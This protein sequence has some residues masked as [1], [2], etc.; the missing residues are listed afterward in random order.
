MKRFNKVILYFVTDK[1]EFLSSS[2]ESVEVA[3]HHAARLMGL[4][5]YQNQTLYVVAY[6]VDLKKTQHK[7]ITKIKRKKK[8]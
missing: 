6:V 7:V 5:K 4:T 8:R 1:K 2:T 3:E